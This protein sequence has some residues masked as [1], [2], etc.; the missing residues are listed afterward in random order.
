[1]NK[2]EKSHDTQ[3]FRVAREI[4][5]SLAELAEPVTNEQVLVILKDMHSKGNRRRFLGNAFW[6]LDNEPSRFANY[7]VWHPRL[8]SL[9]N[10][11]VLGEQM[12]NLF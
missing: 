9:R 8:R 10:N 7:Q 1:M 2:A 4:S 12:F 11:P 3:V 6:L 5:A